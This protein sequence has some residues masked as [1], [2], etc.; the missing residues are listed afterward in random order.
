ME[1]PNL[2]FNHTQK[3]L[4]FRLKQLARNLSQNPNAREFE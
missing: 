3:S 2:A 4:P 1:S